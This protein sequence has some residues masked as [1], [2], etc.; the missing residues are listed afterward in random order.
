MLT[1]VQT[2][3]NVIDV[4]DISTS[5]WFKQATSGNAPDYRVNPCATVAAAPE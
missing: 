5:T 3:M 1:I 2:Q 4:Y